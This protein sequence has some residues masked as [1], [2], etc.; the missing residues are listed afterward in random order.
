MRAPESDFMRICF[1]ADGRYIHAYRWLRFFSSRGHEMHLVS[2]APMQTS[3]VAAVKEAGGRF[4]GE[5]GNFHL[6]RFWFTAR[7]L[8]SLRRVLRRGK[9]QIL[10]CQFLGPNAWFAALCGF[11]PL[12][13]S[14]MGGDV[15]GSDWRPQSS[16]RERILTPL[17]L[18]QADLVT[19]W[20]QMM[21]NVVRPYCRR[22]TKVELIHG[23]IDLKAFTP[24]AKPRHLQERWQL[25]AGAKV[26]FSPRMMRSLSNIDCLAMAAPMICAACPDAYFLFAVPEHVKDNA[27]EDRVRGILSEHALADHARFVGSIPHSEMAEYYR[28]A[29]VMISIPRTDGTPMTVL[30][31]LSC[32]TPVVVSDIADYDHRYIEPGKT[33]LSARPE[34]SR[35]LADCILRLLHDS[36]LAMQLTSEAMRRIVTTASYEAQMSRMEQLYQEL[37]TPGAAE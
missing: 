27:Y 34:D 24:G 6:K 2:F 37:L 10:H 1:F 30:E 25:P 29:D 26:V 16:L 3:H 8:I 36:G 4:Q 11:H 5:I 23:G 20:S 32:A 21:A 15:C 9:I 28:L 22:D 12:V 7:D 19:S 31:S 18:H 13:I 33:V 14:V 17:A 35:A